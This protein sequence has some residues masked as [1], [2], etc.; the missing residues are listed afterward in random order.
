A[1]QLVAQ[2]R[3][4]FTAEHPEQ[5]MSDH[6]GLE[7]SLLFR[8]GHGASENIVWRMPVGTPREAAAMSP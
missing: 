3:R 4:I 1:V 6:M 7:A 8:S 5:R 2:P